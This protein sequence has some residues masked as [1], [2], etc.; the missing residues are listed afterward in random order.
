[1]TL[2]LFLLQFWL[3]TKTSL[4]LLYG[5]LLFWCAGCHLIVCSVMSSAIEGEA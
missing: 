4:S 1:M 2:F 3:G 5:C